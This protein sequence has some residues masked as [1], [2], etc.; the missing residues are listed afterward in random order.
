M[1]ATTIVE[2]FE[3]GSIS[4]IID[5]G[6]KS[7]CAKFHASIPKGTILTHIYCTNSRS[8]HSKVM[9]P[10][11]CSNA[12]WVSCMYQRRTDQLAFDLRGPL[13]LSKP[14]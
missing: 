11:H 1:A 13:P 5:I 7:I 9:S 6:L 10:G 2:H 4:N 3:N 14:I 12:H 8:G